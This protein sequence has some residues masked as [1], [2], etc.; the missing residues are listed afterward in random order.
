MISIEYH[1]LIFIL[2]VGANVCINEMS[3]EDKDSDYIPILA[4]IAMMIIFESIYYGIYI[5]IT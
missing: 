4:A 2:L 1:V 3:E 5:L